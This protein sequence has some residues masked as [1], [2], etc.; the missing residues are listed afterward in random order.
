MIIAYMNKTHECDCE[1][2]ILY[3]YHRSAA[4]GLCIKCFCGVEFYVTYKEVLYNRDYNAERNPIPF[5]RN[6]YFTKDFLGLP[7]FLVIYKK[8]AF[9]APKGATL[10]LGG[11]RCRVIG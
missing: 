9:I 10:I 1:N 2:E 7:L 11:E 6:A 5:I 4:F 3:L 8:Q